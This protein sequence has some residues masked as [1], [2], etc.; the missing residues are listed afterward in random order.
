MVVIAP[1]D[2]LFEKTVSNMSEVIARG[3]QVVLITDAE[4]AAH[5]PAEAQVLIAARAAIR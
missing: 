1:T 3:G 4:G 5:A 2:A